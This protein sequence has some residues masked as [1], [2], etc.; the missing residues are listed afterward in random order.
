MATISPLLRRRALIAAMGGALAASACSTLVTPAQSTLLQADQLTVSGRHALPKADGALAGR[1][2]VGEVVVDPALAKQMALE[3]EAYRALL[4]SA[5]QK[6]LSNY[7]YRAQAGA[8]APCGF[9]WRRRRWSSRRTSRV[10]PR[11]RA[12]GSRRWRPARRNA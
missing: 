4:T 2:E 8:R 11:S 6:S 3:T 1:L 9:G 5:L 7:G 12:C 10:R